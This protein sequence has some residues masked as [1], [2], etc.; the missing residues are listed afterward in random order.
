[1]SGTTSSSVPR[2]QRR[3]R[4]GVSSCLAHPDPNRSYFRKKTLLYS[5]ESMLAYVASGGAFPILVPRPSP[6]LSLEEAVREIDGLVL[7]GGVDMAPESYGESPLDPRWSGD[8]ER[9][10]FEIALIHECHRQGVPVFGICRGMQVLNVALGGTLYQDLE[11]QGAS[12][13]TH[14]SEEQYDQLF[15]EVVF[16]PESHL[17]AVFGTQTGRINSVHHQGV[18]TLGDGLVVEGRAQEDGVI[19]AIRLNDPKKPWTLGV[20]WHPEFQDANDP[21]LLP[22]DPLLNTF[23]MQVR[24]LNA[25]KEADR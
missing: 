20:Q 24:W 17:A 23:M 13:I 15:H 25:Q 21:K 5:E 3:P 22:R 2:T 10:A 18:K 19:E 7:H 4:V 1:M 8:G 16:E 14:R 9:D 12:Q 11:T 6:H